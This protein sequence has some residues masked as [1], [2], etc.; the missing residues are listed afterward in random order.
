MRSML[1]SWTV[2]A[3]LSFLFLITIFTSVSPAAVID[4][5]SYGATGNGA[6]DDTAAIISAMEDLSDNDTLLFP[7][8]TAYY[9]IHYTPEDDHDT[10]GLDGMNLY[11]L[12]GIRVVIQGKIMVSGTPIADRYV[13]NAMYCNDLQFI[14]QGDGAIIEGDGQFMFDPADVYGPCFIRFWVC[15]RG[16]VEN[17]TMIQGPHFTV[18]MR[19][20]EQIKISNCLFQGGPTVFTGTQIHQ[21]AFFGCKN[22]HIDSNRFIPG[23]D[24]GKTMQCVGG[25]GAG[26][27]HS[28]T[29]NHFYDSFDH[30]IY[31]TAI[32]NTVVANNIHVN[33]GGTPIK[34]V[35][36]RN[37]ITNNNINTA[38]GGGI[39][40]RNAENCIIANN[41]IEDFAFTG[42][43]VSTYGGGYDITYDN[44]LIEGNYL[45]GKYF[46]STGRSP[47]EG[48]RI[49]N[50][51]YSVSGTKII[52]N[53]LIDCDGLGT[54]GVWSPVPSYD[55]TIS[56][57]LLDQC[58]NHG[59]YLSNIHDSLVSDNMIN[60]LSGRTPI[61][62][63]GGSS[64]ITEAD[65]LT[66]WY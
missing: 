2:Y 8:P 13:F 16:L 54:I 9:K 26:S 38:P 32:Y 17:L 41:R 1:S 46:S 22:V 20:C 66:S 12:D 63:T 37:L 6:T 57:N 7:R 33:S 25:G 27:Y 24:G 4:V 64:G 52:N 30:S 39:E 40:T 49:T 43:E 65:N 55:V 44:N 19:S 36:S 59:I 60:I 50:S 56:G 62:K 14:G 42:I 23:T 61:V 5:T 18:T 10:A 28:I 58:D 53:V 3:G 11:Y 21:I 15:N 45:R 48:I 47:L 51:S 31:F 35:G 29:N 34:L